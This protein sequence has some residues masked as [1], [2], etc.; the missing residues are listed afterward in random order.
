[1]SHIAPRVAAFASIVVALSP[2][3]ASASR[4]H[5]RSPGRTGSPE[6]VRKP[7]SVRA[8]PERNVHVEEVAAIAAAPWKGSRRL[9]RLPV[10]PGLDAGDRFAPPVQRCSTV[11]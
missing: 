2:A 6:A 1:M 7:G 3:A 8:L 9:M 4:P 5:R 10:S 11:E